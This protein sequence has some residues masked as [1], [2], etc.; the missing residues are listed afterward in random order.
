MKIQQDSKL[1]DRECDEQEIL[2]ELEKNWRES[3]P[4]LSDTHWLEVFPEAR[5]I[6]A[7]KLKEWGAEK[8]RRRVLIQI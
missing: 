6:L 5:G 3:L 7:D 1:P 8:I 4:R 2:F